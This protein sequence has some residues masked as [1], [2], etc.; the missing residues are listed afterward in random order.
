MKKKNPAHLI[1]TALSRQEQK[2]QI[3]VF[4]HYNESQRIFPSLL[5]SKLFFSFNS[6]SRLSAGYIIP[7]PS[8]T[9]SRTN[10]ST[11]KINEHS[12]SNPAHLSNF[13]SAELAQSCQFK[14]CLGKKAL[15]DGILSRSKLSQVLRKST[16]ECKTMALCLI[17]ELG[18]SMLRPYSIANE[19]Q[20]F[21]QIS[22][23][24]ENGTGSVLKSALDIYS[25]IW[26]HRFVPHV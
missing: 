4:Q 20:V 21:D 11:V 18:F 12:I 9:T 3:R 24:A 15:A 22:A 13:P 25:D 10:A 23:R 6:F 8:H 5:T 2:N 7:Q 1:K 17:L 19:P 16:I 14:T 26:T